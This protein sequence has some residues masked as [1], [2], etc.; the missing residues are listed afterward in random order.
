MKGIKYS[1]SA[2]AKRGWWGLITYPKNVL[3]KGCVSYQTIKLIGTKSVREWWRRAGLM[4]PGSFGWMLALGV[5]LLKPIV[6]TSSAASVMSFW[7]QAGFCCGLLRSRVGCRDTASPALVDRMGGGG[8]SKMCCCC[9]HWL[10]L[11]GHFQFGLKQTLS[12]HMEITLWSV[13]VY[14]FIS[15]VIVQNVTILH[16]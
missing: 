11:Q 8:C 5:D 10:P 9:Y 3:E 14:M 15:G 13:I 12:Q 7:K 16:L 6:F 1:K 2:V 4:F